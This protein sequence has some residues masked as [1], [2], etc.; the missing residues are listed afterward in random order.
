MISHYRK[1]ALLCGLLILP[2]ALLAQPDDPHASHGAQTDSHAGHSQPESNATDSTGRTVEAHSGHVEQSAV[3]SSSASP[4]PDHSTMDHGQMRMQGG[5]AP[6]DARDPHA[7]SDGYTL[8]EGPYARPGPRQL[9]LMDEHRFWSV[10]GDRVEYDAD[11]KTAAFDLQGWYGTTY[12]RLVVKLEGEVEEGTLKE[13]E[14]DVL[15]GRA[16]NAYFDTQLGVSFDQNDEGEDRQWLAFGIKGLA[17]Y[18]FELDATAYLG[19]RGRS[20]LSVEAEYELLFTQRLVLQPRAELALYGKDDPANRR[21]SGLS[22]AALGLRLRYEFSRQFAPYLG[23]EW[24]GS[25]GKTA[26]FLRADGAPVR[27]TRLMAGVR[28]W[29]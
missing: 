6:A 4:A 14:T 29:F 2:G 3:T 22:T 7:Y 1:S 16:L 21:G 28:F 13:S 27:D 10:L 8:T 11:S 12:N 9:I 24:T 23:L 5:D 17:P 25:F 20:A 18:W 26:D 15:W 19:E